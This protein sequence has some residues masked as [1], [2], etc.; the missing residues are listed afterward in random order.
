MVA[1]KR[2]RPRPAKAV[3][4]F[5]VLSSEARSQLARTANYVGSPHHT[6]IPK[7]GMRSQP[8]SGAVTIDV[9]EEEGLKNPTCTVCPRKWARRQGDA[10]SLLCSAIQA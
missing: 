8:R 10:T 3:P 9:A 7:Y 2:P 4:A 5:E 6:D 1:F